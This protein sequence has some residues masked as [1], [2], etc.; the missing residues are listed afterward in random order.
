MSKSSRLRLLDVRQAFRLIGECR[1]LGNDSVAWRLRSFEGLMQLIRARVAIGGEMRWRKGHQRP[2]EVIQ[3][4]D[5]GFEPHEH[6]LFSRVMREGDA[7]KH[8]VTAPLHRLSGRVITRTR[9]QL[10]DDPTWYR[11]VFF[12]EN[13][14]PIGIDHC[15]NTLCKLPAAGS[16]N[17]IGLHR[18]PGDHDFSGRDRRLLHLF[19]GELGRLVGTALATAGVDIFSGLSPRLRQTLDCLLEGDG[20]KQVAARLGLSLPTVHQ[21]VTALYRH[22]GVGSRAELLARFIRRPRSGPE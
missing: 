16:F 12:N 7:S 13:V 2:L 15:V 21:Y 9:R 8:P 10:V 22:F 17:L 4:L 6:A 3:S 5:V 19:H 14:K 1:D 11:S 18:A 20:E